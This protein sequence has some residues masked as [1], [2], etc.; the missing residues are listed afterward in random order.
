[1]QTDRTYKT[2][3]S[4]VEW[5]PKTSVRK[6][7]VVRKIQQS[8]N[9]EG[10]GQDTVMGDEAAQDVR[11]NVDEVEVGNVEQ[12]R[13]RKKFERILKM[14]LEKRVEGERSSATKSM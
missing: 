7:K 11:V 1:M 12:P 14:K 5:P 3:Y 8:V 13:K 2:T 9:I 6:R 10:V 4:Q